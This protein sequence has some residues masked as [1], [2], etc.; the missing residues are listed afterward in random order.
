M[1]MHGAAIHLPQTELTAER[2]ADTLSGLD[3]AQLLT[4][5]KAARAVGKPQ[6]AQTV[7]AVIERVAR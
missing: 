4:M 3:R 2:L 6:A 1:A 5:A 7:A